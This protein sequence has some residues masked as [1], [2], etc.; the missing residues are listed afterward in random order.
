LVGGTLAVLIFL[1]FVLDGGCWDIFNLGVGGIFFGGGGR[2]LGLLRN[3]FV[4]LEVVC[5]FS[6][7]VSE[8]APC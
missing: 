3:V 5:C 4:L 2:W 7:I 8:G 1:S 6:E